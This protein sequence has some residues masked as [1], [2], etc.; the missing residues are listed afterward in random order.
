MLFVLCLKSP[1]IL[2]LKFEKYTKHFE[3]K[4]KGNGYI[5]HYQN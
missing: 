3:K 4:I 5:K 1:L 2:L